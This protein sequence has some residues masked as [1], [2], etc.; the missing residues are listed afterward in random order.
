MV[1]Q[2]ELS[3]LRQSQPVPQIGG[4]E[5]ATPRMMGNGRDGGTKGLFIFAFRRPATA[6]NDETTAPLTYCIL[7]LP[8]NKRSS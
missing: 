4:L 1:M 6:G 5:G 7:L 2:A 3:K 8:A